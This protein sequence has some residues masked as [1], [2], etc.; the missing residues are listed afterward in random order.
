MCNQQG[1]PKEH[2]KRWH[3][4]KSYILIEKEI[5]RIVLHVINAPRLAGERN[6]RQ[7]KTKQ[8]KNKT[9]DQ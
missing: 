8:R 7:A 2:S 3:L 9:F 5:M 1:F 4:K 6:P